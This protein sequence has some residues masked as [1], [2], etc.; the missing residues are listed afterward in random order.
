MQ[1][2]LIE[3][4]S[5]DERAEELTDLD[6]QIRD[7]F[8]QEYLVD[9]DALAAC[10]RIGFAKMFAENYAK[11]FM[12]ET[13]VRNRIAQLQAHEALNPKQEANEDKRRIRSMLF[14]EANYHGPG[15]SHGARVSALAKLASIY[16]MD[17]PIKTEN[18]HTH[19][20]NVMRI[21]AQM[22]EDT[23]EREAIESQTE[24]ARDVRH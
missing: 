21:P 7:Q 12:S 2:E 23:W 3:L 20:G 16:S 17:G 9:Y 4:I 6:R 24:L 8:A 10:V 11:K 15:S 18:L 1:E 13:Y 5:E 22:D 14:K 19:R